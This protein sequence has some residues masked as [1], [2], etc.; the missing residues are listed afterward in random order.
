[1]QT[2]L[3]NLKNATLVSMQHQLTVIFWKNIQ[4][5]QR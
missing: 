5:T 4:E 1:M 2:V 3:E